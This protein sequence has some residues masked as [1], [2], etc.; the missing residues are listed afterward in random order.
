M[1]SNL[2]QDSNNVL[3]WFWTL[4]KP[5]NNNHARQTKQEHGIENV[6]FSF[7][8]RSIYNHNH[9]NH[10]PSPPKVTYRQGRHCTTKMQKRNNSTYSRLKSDSESLQSPLSLHCLYINKTV[11]DHTQ[12]KLGKVNV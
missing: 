4:I 2:L 5:P 12:K 1:L 9:H 7:C 8:F 6:F 10:K 11:H 3:W